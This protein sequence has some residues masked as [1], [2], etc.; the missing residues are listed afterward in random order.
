MLARSLQDP[1]DRLLRKPVDLQVGMVPPQ[2]ARDR[3]VPPG[4]PKTDR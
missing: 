4:M 2:L 1:S 3:H